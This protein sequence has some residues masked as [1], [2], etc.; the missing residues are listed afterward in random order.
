MR[1]CPPERTLFDI[2]LLVTVASLI[3]VATLATIIEIHNE[4]IAAETD[5][6]ATNSARPQPANH[7]ILS[8]RIH[9]NE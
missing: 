4:M 8:P 9:A 2:T 6:E 3:V 1:P 5:A 7:S